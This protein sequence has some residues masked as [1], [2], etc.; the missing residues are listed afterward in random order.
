MTCDRCSEFQAHLDYLEDVISRHDVEM[1]DAREEARQYRN[2]S[3]TLSAENQ[4]LTAELD[5][6]SKQAAQ[7]ARARARMV[8]PSTQPGPDSCPPTGIK[9]PAGLYVVRDGDVA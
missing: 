6:Q 3:E 9:R 4:R 5:K 1:Q 8:H 7:D 2:T